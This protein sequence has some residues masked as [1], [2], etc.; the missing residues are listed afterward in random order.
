[1]CSLNCHRL[2]FF[3]FASI[4]VIEDAKVN[5]SP[6]V[7]SNSAAFFFL[8]SKALRAQQDN[9]TPSTLSFLTCLAY[10]VS[11][12]MRSPRSLHSS[13]CFCLVGSRGSS[14]T[15]CSSLSSSSETIPAC[16]LKRVFMMAPGL[17][18]TASVFTELIACTLIASNLSFCMFSTFPAYYSSLSSLLFLCFSL[19]LICFS[20]RSQITLVT[21]GG[22][23][24]I[25]TKP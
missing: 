7:H 11:A 17:R 18:F 4:N 23:I 24:S 2:F 12:F 20:N 14:S 13:A 5:P 15:Y 25:S 21:M 3:F 10:E 8:S 1:M 6:S 19:Q 16:Y 22:L 9:S